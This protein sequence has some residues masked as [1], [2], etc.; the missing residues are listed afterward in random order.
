[1]TTS[2]VGSWEGDLSTPGM[3][4]TVIAVDM[5]REFSAFDSVLYLVGTKCS[6]LLFSLLCFTSSARESS[7]PEIKTN[8]VISAALLFGQYFRN[9]PESQNSSMSSACSSMPL[10]LINTTRSSNLSL[11]SSVVG[12]WGLSEGHP[13]CSDGSVFFHLLSCISLS[14]NNSIA[15][16][17]LHWILSSNEN[18]FCQ[19]HHFVTS[20]C[21]QG[22][23]EDGLSDWVNEKGISCIYS[24]VSYTCH[25]TF[26]RGVLGHTAF[27]NYL[28]LWFWGMFVTTVKSV[29]V[30]NC[31][32]VAGD[33]TG[34]LF[35]VCLFVL[36]VSIKCTFSMLIHVTNVLWT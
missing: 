26:S 7:F 4:L 28:K 12:S 25:V 2:Q 17:S 30:K 29:Y 6:S 35:F 11:D 3:I 22:E 31:L 8:D 32:E 10:L 24:I 21:H 16:M 18:P 5:S 34:F 36:S 33:F 20:T 13:I 14:Y 15:F 1:M 27:R 23:V 19:Q 9:V